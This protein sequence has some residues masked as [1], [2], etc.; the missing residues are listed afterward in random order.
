MLF[1]GLRSR[2]KLRVCSAL[3]RLPQTVRSYHHPHLLPSL[4]RHRHASIPVPNNALGSHCPLHG[5]DHRGRCRGYS[6][7]A[8]HPQDRMSTT[9][10][11]AGVPSLHGHGKVL[12]ADGTEKLVE[13][14]MQ[15][16]QVLVGAQPGH[17]QQSSATVVCVLETVFSGSSPLVD[18]VAMPSGLLLSPYLP[19][20]LHH[21]ADHHGW[22]FPA[23]LA[24]EEH[25]NGEPQLK[26]GLYPCR[27]MY[28]FVLSQGHSIV[29]NGVHC[30]T[31]GHQ[32]K[33]VAT[34][35]SPSKEEQDKSTEETIPRLGE[36]QE[37]RV[38]CEEGARVL[39]HPFWGTHK[40]L[41][42]L[43][44]LRG[45]RT[46]H[47]VLSGNANGESECLLRNLTTH[48]VCGIQQQPGFV[49][50][51]SPIPYSPSSHSTHCPFISSPPLSSSFSSYF[52]SP[53]SSPRS[54]CHPRRLLVPPTSSRP[55]LPH[56]SPPNYPHP[57]FNHAAPDSPPPSLHSPSPS[58]SDHD[59]SFVFPPS[60]SSKIK[61]RHGRRKSRTG[62]DQLSSEGL[63]SNSHRV[64]GSLADLQFLNRRWSWI[65]GAE[66]IRPLPTTLAWK[67]GFNFLLKDT[68]E[69]STDYI[70]H[71][72]FG[73]IPKRHKTTGK[74]AI[75][76]DEVPAYKVH[77]FQPNMFPYA[78]PQETLHYIMWYTWRP[79]F[80]T[81]R[82]ICRDITMALWDKLHHSRFD[83]VW[84]ENP[85]M[86][87]PDIYHVQVFWVDLDKQRT[88]EYYRELAA[89]GGAPCPFVCQDTPPAEAHA[90][91][92]M[93]PMNGTKKDAMLKP[94]PWRM[95]KTKTVDESGGAGTKKPPVPPTEVSLPAVPMRPATNSVSMGSP[96]HPQRQ[97]QAG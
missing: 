22:Q 55:S 72:V 30:I 95:P 28:S 15:G 3:C 63:F 42:A 75:P 40:V 69:T 90:A 91:L 44:K 11:L 48:E 59:F 66:N 65:P 82:M 39:E 10:M 14:V 32:Y 51:E 33:A 20:H 24:E 13:D 81:D 89:C 43:S 16:D 18:L 64:S 47:I 38:L 46:G 84:Y 25:D 97:T 78:L 49:K 80:L 7:E 76:R 8:T 31:L 87:I 93:S 57:L 67:E 37:Q 27:A 74:L 53:L 71:S 58:P 52:L 85:K 79:P 36:E 21:G 92:S 54:S 45:W 17:S 26:R 23:E 5:L 73:F 94:L 61:Q 83:F 88:A 70:L 12:M 1:I 34:H 29:V 62:L 77:R 86:S 19:V 50:I 96:R 4:S 68:Y 2:S 35:V 9:P 41:D 60:N 6:S 56:S